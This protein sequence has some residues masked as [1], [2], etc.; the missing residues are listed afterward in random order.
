MLFAATDI[1]WLALLFSALLGAGFIILN[2]TSQTLIQSAVDPTFR[3]RVIS[4]H[5]LVMLGVPALGA[6]LLGGVA[7]HFGLRIPVFAGGAICVGVWCMTWRKRAALKISLET[8]P[9]SP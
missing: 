6:L 4:V 2:V 5:G 9:T 8:A 1:F 3:G 7:E